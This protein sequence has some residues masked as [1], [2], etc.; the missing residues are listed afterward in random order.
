MDETEIVRQLLNFW[1][2]W[3]GPIK[4]ASQLLVVLILL[5]ILW[6]HGRAIDTLRQLVHQ[7]HLREAKLVM[8]VLQL[9]ARCQ[10]LEIDAK[11]SFGGGSSGGAAR[12]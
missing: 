2:E 11:R 6:L 10:A 9:Q 4:E 12:S 3:Q 8:S 5:A 1:G 7:S